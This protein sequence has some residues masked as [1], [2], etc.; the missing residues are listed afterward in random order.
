[1]KTRSI[2]SKRAKGFSIRY[3]V[4]MI[5]LALGC[6]KDENTSNTNTQETGSNQ[7]EDNSNT[8]T[9]ETGKRTLETCTTSIDDNAPAFYKTYFKCVT[10]SM[11]GMDVVI[12]SENLPPHDTFYYDT[13]H[14]NHIAYTPANE[15]SRKVPGFLEAQNIRMTIPASPVSRNLTIDASLVD[16]QAQS[17][18]NEYKM[19]TA[20]IALDSVAIFNSLARPGDSIEDE[21]ATFDAYAAH[22]AGGNYHYHTA[23]RG[24]LEVLQ[25]AGIISNPT[26]GS[27]E[28]EVYGIMCDGSLVLGCTELNGDEPGSNNLDAQNGH[29]HDITDHLGETHFSNRY[30]TH[31]CPGETPFQGHSYTPEIQHY[32]EC[33]IR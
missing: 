2:Y 4:L 6:G 11:D 22:H 20:G 27:A 28:I 23:T 16:A 15:D 3:W 18:N 21:I 8:N 29:S 13:D 25:S 1:M 33:S 24:P 32:T 7:N 26:P 17:S 9:Q 31:L 12:E 10:I 30:H 5:L 14:A 19:G